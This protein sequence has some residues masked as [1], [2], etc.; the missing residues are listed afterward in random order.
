MSEG[1]FT[2]IVTD[3]SSGY[4]VVIQLSTYKIGL[5]AEIKFSWFIDTFITWQLLCFRAEYPQY[6]LQAIYVTEKQHFVLW[7]AQIEML[8]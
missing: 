2:D 5:D 3:I 8:Y 1:T 7:E 4:C 6:M